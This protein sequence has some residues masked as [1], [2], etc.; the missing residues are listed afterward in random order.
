MAKS[1]VCKKNH[2]LLGACLMLWGPLFACFSGSRYK[3]KKNTLYNEPAPT[4]KLIL[5]LKVPENRNP[6]PDPEPMA[7]KRSGIV[8]K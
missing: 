6:K 5:T 1:I 7:Q 3:V 2:R 4:L 8:S